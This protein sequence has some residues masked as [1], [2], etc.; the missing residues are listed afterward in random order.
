M[1]IDGRAPQYPVMP[2]AEPTRVD[3]FLVGLL[4]VCLIAIAVLIAVPLVFLLVKSVWRI[5]LG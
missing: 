3:H 4:V 2:N 5:A 1:T